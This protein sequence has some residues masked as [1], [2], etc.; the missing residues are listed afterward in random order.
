MVD[1]VLDAIQSVRMY[2]LRFLLASAGVFWG[3]LMLTYLTEIVGAARRHYESEIEEVGARL[4]YVFPGFVT[5]A[6]IGERGA[7]PV[8][9]EVDDMSHVEAFDSVAGVDPSIELDA[10][11]R[12]GGRTRLLTVFGVSEAAA[13]VRGFAAEQGRFLSRIDVGSRARVAFLGAKAAQRIFGRRDVVGRTLQID[14]LVFRVVGVAAPKGRQIIDVTGQDDEA[15]LIPYTTLVRWFK[16]DERL[17]H[18][19]YR[20]RTREESWDTL[21]HVRQ[22]IA[23]Q[24]HFDPNSG[25]SLTFFNTEEPL[26]IVRSL[27]GALSLFASCAGLSTLLIGSVGVMNIML[28]VARERTRE[29][30]V[31]KAIGATDGAILRLFFLEGAMVASFAAILGCVTAILLFEITIVMLPGDAPLARA[32][33]ADLA[34]ALAS[35]CVL[36]STAVASAVL[37]AYRAARTS[38]AEALRT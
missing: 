30:G 34:V 29:I 6:A 19:L 7:R 9:L 21:R 31:R 15:V 4:V 24:H 13:D 32:S 10:V 12:H 27:F 1:L 25:D 11:V 35:V 2:K 26:T 14:S 28:V 38:P 18:L 5:K 36:A 17:E 37:P 33:A 8:A 16:R 20:A 3:A 22:A 23:L